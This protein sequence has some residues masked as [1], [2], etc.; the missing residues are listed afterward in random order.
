MPKG[1]GFCQILIQPQGAR[2]ASCNL[3]NLK[4]MREARAVMVALGRNEHL[5]FMLHAAEGFAMDDAVSVALKIRP[6]VAFFLRSFSA[7]R[8]TAFRGIFPEDFS[9]QFLLKL[10]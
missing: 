5:R 3:R 7:L 2:N 4:R 8:L 10:P 6:N 1:N 9:L